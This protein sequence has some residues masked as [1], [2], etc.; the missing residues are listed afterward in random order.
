M[1]HNNFLY[2]L[3]SLSRQIRAAFKHRTRDYPL[4]FE[5]IRVI[6]YIHRF[7]GL[8]Q[9][10]LADLLEIRPITATKLLCMLEELGLVIR[11]PDQNDKRAR[12]LR[13]TPKGVDI[14]NEMKEVSTELFQTLTKNL[15]LDDIKT[16]HRLIGQLQLGT[17]EIMK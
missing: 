14:A 2:P 15:S 1:A 6:A 16:L 9:R 3:I 7:E 4:S 10:R 5:Q 13:L 17:E 8:S 11:E 12:M